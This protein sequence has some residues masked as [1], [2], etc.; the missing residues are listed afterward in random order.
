MKALLLS[1][2][3][4]AATPALAQTTTSATGTAP[5]G[6]PP[7]ACAA[8]EFSQFS[9]WIGHWDVYPTGTDTMVAHSLIEGLYNGCAIREN[10]MP[11]KGPG[12]GSLSGYDPGQKGWRQTWIGGGGG[13]VDFKGG[14]HGKAMV[15]T[16]VWP[17]S[18][19]DGSD[20]LVRM[21]YT[22]EEGGA[23]RQLGEISADGGKTW[24]PSFDFSY[25]P[26]KAS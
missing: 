3:L 25:R 24:Q 2:L 19:P 13:W 5:T 4:L 14:Y 22:R 17:R 9:F 12:G 18:L 26:A 15:L 11:L 1:A 16:G 23:V 21:T 7:P 20:G 10:W 6:P 8:P